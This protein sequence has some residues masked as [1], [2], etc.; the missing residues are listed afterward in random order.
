MNTQSA[1]FNGT[2]LSNL[3]LDEDGF[4]DYDHYELE[5][6]RL[7]ARTVGSFFQQAGRFLRRDYLHGFRRL[8]QR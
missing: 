7:Q 5:G 1:A 4:I 2:D 3:K 8:H 6:R